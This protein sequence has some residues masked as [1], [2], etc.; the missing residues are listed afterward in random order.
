MI[1]LIAAKLFDARFMGTALTA[2]AAAATAVAIAQPFLETDRL[3]KRMKLVSDEREQI[4][5]RRIVRVD[6]VAQAHR[7]AGIQQDL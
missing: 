7:P 4:R 3:G 1:D 2:V 5:R 6:G